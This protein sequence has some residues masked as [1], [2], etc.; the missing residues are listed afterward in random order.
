MASFIG[1]QQQV[2]F[3]IKCVLCQLR[4]CSRFSSIKYDK[5]GVESK[6][7][8]TI[9]SLPVSSNCTPLCNT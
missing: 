2:T 1:Q 6:Q 9:K 7:S 5:I 3:K 4:S 8:N